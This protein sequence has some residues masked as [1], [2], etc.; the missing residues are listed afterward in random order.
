MCW[1]ILF[2]SCAVCLFNLLIRLF[3]LV[4]VVGVFWGHVYDMLLLFLAV[5]IDV[6][7]LVAAVRFFFY[8]L[9]VV[10]LIVW[11]M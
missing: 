6:R 11:C 9:C 5:V 3:L 2:I 1:G 10:L 4:F 7:L 8:G